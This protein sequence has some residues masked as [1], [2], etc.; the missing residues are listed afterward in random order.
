[1][2]TLQTTNP[3]KIPLAVSA[4]N[5]ASEAVIGVPAVVIYKRCAWTLGA[6]P[7]GRIL[8]LLSFGSKPPVVTVSPDILEWLIRNISKYPLMYQDLFLEYRGRIGV[9]KE[10]ARH[11]IAICSDKGGSVPKKSALTLMMRME[12]RKMEVNIIGDGD[13]FGLLEHRSDLF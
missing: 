8:I 7:A 10:V 4:G 6:R 3:S 5:M 1:M 2:R 13:L 12:R 9:P 11:D